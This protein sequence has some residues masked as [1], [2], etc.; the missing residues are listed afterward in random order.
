MDDLPA[1]PTAIYL[2]LVP[3]IQAFKPLLRANASA[4]KSARKTTHRYGPHERQQ[5]DV[6][7]PAKPTDPTGKPAPILVF[8]YGGGFQNGDKVCPDPF[9]DDLIYTNL[10]YFFR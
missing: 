6:Y 4:I 2:S 9:P 5:L 8:I 3:T 1:L 10:G 7:E